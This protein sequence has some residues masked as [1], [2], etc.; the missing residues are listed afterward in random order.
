MSSKEFELHL[1]ADTESEEDIF[2]DLIPLLENQNLFSKFYIIR[3]C[4]YDFSVIDVL[5][6]LKEE[7]IEEDF[8]K[9]T[10]DYNKDR[11]FFKLESF[12]KNLINNM[13]KHFRF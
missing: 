6:T 13:G 12:I 5:R 1:L 3:Y 8:S 11:D 7:E 10:F 9:S 2:S 4:F